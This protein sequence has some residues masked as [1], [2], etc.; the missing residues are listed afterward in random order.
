M[1]RLI[2]PTI[3]IFFTAVGIILNVN[4]PQ[5]NLILK[6]IIN[7]ILYGSLA[8]LFISLG[9]IF[10][11][12]IK[13]YLCNNYMPRISKNKIGILFDVD[14]QYAESQEFFNRS[15][16]NDFKKE[17][18]SLSDE[19]EIHQLPIKVS[20]KI[21]KLNKDDQQKFLQNHNIILYLNYNIK[22]E[23]RN[24]S[25]KHEFIITDV[26]ALD[27]S[28]EIENKLKELL[29][30]LFAPIRK[31][32]FNED[33]HLEKIDEYNKDLNLIC[34]YIVG[35]CFLIHSNFQS[36]KKSFSNAYSLLN[37]L[38]YVKSIYYGL[39]KNT[40]ILSWHISLLQFKN[41]YFNDVTSYIKNFNI[42]DKLVTELDDT[43]NILGRGLAEYYTIKARHLFIKMSINSSMDRTKTYMDIKNFNNK[44]RAEYSRIK[45]HTFAQNIN[46]VFFAVYEQCSAEA[47]LKK[48]DRLLNMPESQEYN[49]IG[50]IGFIE[51]IKQY[52][53]NYHFSLLLAEYYR[54]A[55][56]NMLDQS[57][58]CYRE[59]LNHCNKAD[60]KTINERLSKFHIRV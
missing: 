60:K 29:N 14:C 51:D 32:L 45:M 21:K 3:S 49:Y 42:A 46:D 57:R 40:H 27:K 7:I 37:S 41:S 9:I 4:Y 39:A 2:I 31:C 47:I 1:K 48:I 25:P 12:W 56:D 24:T 52:Y 17:L 23:G 35:I 15:F 5:A 16:F 8:G 19:L 18:E 50:I 58:N 30:I 43:K 13:T 20:K 55:S 28:A 54:F 44:A 38:C 33:Q 59:F 53:D 6:V 11:S 34:N 26:Q 22:T 10:I 36:A